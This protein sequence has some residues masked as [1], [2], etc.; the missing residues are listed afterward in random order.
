MRLSARRV[1]RP[2][3]RL[4]RWGQDIGPLGGIAQSAALL[5]QHVRQEGAREAHDAA[6]NRG[7]LAVRPVAKHRTYDDLALL[8]GF[9]QSPARRR[10]LPHGSGAP[11]LEFTTLPSL[12][13][14]FVPI[15]MQP[16]SAGLDQELKDI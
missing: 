9:P 14:H 11:S 16:K 2:D 4:G 3:I 7:R 1:E 8:Q 6:L 15:I 12:P 13:N 10:A 5:Q